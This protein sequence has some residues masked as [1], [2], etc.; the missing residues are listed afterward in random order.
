MKNIYIII[1]VTAKDRKEAEKI[2]RGL[3]EAKLIACANIVEGVKSLF[4]WQGKIDSSNEALLVLK[5]KKILF[6][7]V[8][9][10]VKSLHSY[11]T[12]E[13]IA[14]PIIN[15]SEDYLKWVDLST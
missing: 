2:A 12:P 1:L 9:I 5:T 15:G 11:Q 6:K 4:W 10:K 7:K 14:L 8:L 13:I 3:L